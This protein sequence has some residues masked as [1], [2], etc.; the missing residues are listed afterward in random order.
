MIP[1]FDE[2]SSADLNAVKRYA[3][4]AVPSTSPFGPEPELDTRNERLMREPREAVAEEGVG[5]LRPRARVQKDQPAHD[6]R[7]RERLLDEGR[8]AA[9]AHVGRRN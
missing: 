4:I 9:H 2:E 8:P 6:L 7:R 5:I 1:F 3:A